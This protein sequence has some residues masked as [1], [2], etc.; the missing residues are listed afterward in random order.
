MDASKVP[1]L[2]TSSV[3][4]HDAGVRLKNPREREQLA[5][6][7][8]HRW[9]YYAPKNPLVLCDGSGFDFA[10]LVAKLSIDV[11]IEC[12]RF[13]NDADVVRRH[14]RG[15]GEGEIVRFAIENSELIKAAGC[16]AKCTSKLWVENF[17]ECMAQWNGR[18]LLK[19]VF[20]EAFSLTRS[21]R[22]SYI[23]TRF[24]AIS[25]DNY[26][27]H[28]LHAHEAIQASTGHGLEECFRDIFLSLSCPPALMK[29]PPVICGVGGGTGKYYKNTATRRLKERLRYLLIT[30]DPAFKTWFAA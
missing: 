11:R 6:E 16:F 25:V 18:I 9:R 1:I 23:D 26:L 8:I 14:G 21:T 19:G 17:S 15:F 2:L 29:C 22:F 30:R 4:A 24:Y 5:L 28:F 3:I 27:K 10:P 12:L 13:Q 7:S 20:E